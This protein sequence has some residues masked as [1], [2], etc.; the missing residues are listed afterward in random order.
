MLGLQNER[1]WAVFCDRVLQRP[2]LARDE[3]FASTSARSRNRAALKAV[4]L[5][6]FASLTAAEVAQRLDAAQIAN[7]RVNTM[8]Q[9]WDHP[10][11]RARDRWRDVGTPV[12]PIPALLPPGLGPS[13]DPRMGAV[14]ALGEHTDAILAGMGFDPPAIAAL[15]AEGAI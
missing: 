3:R 6:V 2:E 10:Q 7:A 12:G 4:I 9:V 11:L 8:Q 15:R 13:D 5:G 14:P 1:E